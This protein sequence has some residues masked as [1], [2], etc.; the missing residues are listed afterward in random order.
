MPSSFASIFAPGLFNGSV[1]IVTGGG[2]GI[3]RCTAHE[4]AAL[5][6]SVAIVGRNAK[7]LESVCEELKRATDEAQRCSMHVCDIRNE[8]LPPNTKPETPNNKHQTPNMH[9]GNTH[10]VFQR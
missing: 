3:G 7:K 4:L 10:A 1:V 6:A 8:S 9:E 2:S 5:G